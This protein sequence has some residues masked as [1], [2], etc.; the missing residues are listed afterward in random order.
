MGVFDADIHEPTEILG[1]ISHVLDIDRANLNTEG[2]MDYRWTG[3]NPEPFSQVERKTWEDV[4]TINAL[5]EVEEQLRRQLHLHPEAKNRLLLEGAMEP[6]F[7]GVIV[8]TRMKGKDVLNGR[9]QKTSVG[10]FKSVMSWVASV[11]EYMEV[12]FSASYAGT[13]STL[14]ALYEHDNKPLDEHSTF[15]RH[16]K[17]N[18]WKPN[19]QVTKMLGVTANHEPHWGVVICER[20]IAR[21]GTVWRVCQA[22]P[23]EIAEVNGV[24]EASAKQFL[25]AI[26]RL[27]V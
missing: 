23:R 22:S 17:V 3:E 16:F 24:S 1:L 14:I 21:F 19:P 7:D 25:R 11:S 4:A 10:H 9:H 20:L 15:R 27:D 5:N 8:Y 13:A 18:N 26:G 6:T 12:L 2:L